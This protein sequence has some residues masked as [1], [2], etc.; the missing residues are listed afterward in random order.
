ME[1][2]SNTYKIKPAGRHLLTIG[3]D[4][5]QD[6]IAAIVELVK[7]AYD[8]D[9]PYVT[10]SF[11]LRKSTFN[12]KGLVLSPQKSRIHITVEDH[13]HGMSF[14]DVTRKWLVPSTPEKAKR[15]ISPNGRIMQGKK[16]IGRYAASI[17]GS[18]LR[19]ATIDSKKNKTTVFIDWNEFEEAEFLN[20][21]DVE[22]KSER[23]NE[24][25]GTKLIMIC[26][27][28]DSWDLKAIKKLRFEL[29]KLMPPDDL[30]DNDDF[31][32]FLRF[33][34]YFME[35]AGVEKEEEIT[36]FPL[37]DFYDYRIHG[38]VNSSGDVSL[39]YINQRVRNILEEKIEFNIDETGCGNIKFDI[40]V[41]DREPEAIEHLRNRGLKDEITGNFLNKTE[42]KHLL[43]SLKGIGVYRNGFRIRPLGDPNNDWLELDSRRVQN[44]TMRISSNQAIGY[45]KIESEDKSKLEE[46]SARDGLKDNKAFERLIE[47][48][49]EVIKQLEERRFSFRRKEGLSRP[50]SKTEKDIDKLYDF[51]DIKK[52]IKKVLKEVNISDEAFKNIERIIDKEQYEKNILVDEIK[53]TIAIYQ[54]QATL[55]KIIN[56]VLHEGRHPLSYFRNQIKNMPFFIDKFRQKK[57]EASFAKLISITEGFWENGKIIASLFNKIDPLAARKRSK[58][59]KFNLYEAIVIIEKIFENELKDNSIK[60]EVVGNKDIEWSGWKQDIYTIF[61]NLVD[62]SLFWLTHKNL[63]EKEILV[64]IEEEDG[65]WNINYSDTGP[66]IESKYLKSGIIFDPEFSTKPNG[67]GSGLG[68]AIAGEAAQRNGLKLKALESNNG[69][70]FQL[71]MDEELLK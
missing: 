47:I 69:A 60:L 67:Q 37:F 49:Q 44:P 4:L 2:T 36:A 30:K 40:R 32:I 50:K 8:A 53:A 62:N 71:Y 59:E 27:E 65:L 28:C 54:G 39:K 42:T 56:V 9:S 11:A 57:D 52:E 61:T 26:D 25:Q 55:G 20:D 58:P 31:R 3:R 18:V 16:G 12:S 14:E 38:V 15:K 64:S 29:K 45:V 68:L 46:K 41:Y 23:T 1:K 6:K 63:V 34:K 5:I 33:D 13:G 66:G 43:D 51:E 22:I 17:L 7:N 19:M 10:V 24:Q 35:I 70:F 48:T 21:V